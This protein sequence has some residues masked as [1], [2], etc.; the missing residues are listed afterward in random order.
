[1]K[2]ILLISTP[3]LLTGCINLAPDYERPEAP[4]PEAWPDEPSTLIDGNSAA[5][6][7]RHVRRR[8][9]PKARGPGTLS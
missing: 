2:R 6:D 4:I 8:A 5:A 7:W 3:L 1:M 9:S